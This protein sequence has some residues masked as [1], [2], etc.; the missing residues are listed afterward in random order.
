MDLLKPCQG[1][2][3]NWWF[4]LVDILGL[5]SSRSYRGT[6]LFKS[7]RRVTLHTFVSLYAKSSEPGSILTVVASVRAWI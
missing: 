1:W 6:L 2:S 7:Y 4:S 5:P 3:C